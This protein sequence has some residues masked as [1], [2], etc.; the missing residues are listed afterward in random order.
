LAAAGR[1]A[2]GD[3]TLRAGES[4]TLEADFSVEAGGR[5]AVVI[6]STLTDL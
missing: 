3:L 2:T 5:F 6:D 1:P 4:V